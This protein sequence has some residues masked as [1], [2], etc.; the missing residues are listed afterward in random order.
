MLEGLCADEC[1]MVGVV[2]LCSPALVVT[3]RSVEYRPLGRSGLKVSAVSLGSWL[4]M[5][6]AIDQAGSDSLVRR[7]FDLG[8]NLFDTADVYHRG[9]G[10]TALGRAIEGIA[11]ERLVIATKCFFPMSGDVNDRGLSRKHI[12]ESVHGSLGR[13][14]TDYLDLYQCHRP[15]PETPVEETA[16]AM[17]DLIRQGKVLYWGVSYWPAALIAQ[18]VDFCNGADL[19]PPVSNQPPYNLFNREIE[20]DVLSVSEDVGLSQIVYSPLAQG[21]LTG[22]YRKDQDPQAGSR[23]ANEKVNQFIGQYLTDERLQQAARLV[24]LAT[25]H[26]MTPGQMALAWCLRQPNVSSVIVGASRVEQLEENVESVEKKL[27]SEA[28]SH[29]EEIFPA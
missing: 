13:L 18:A 3:F 28:L 17:S 11:R 5:G 7:A 27:S 23:A 16:M 6:N 20:T 10:E 12:F 25:S 22:K 29:L 26:G 9:E 19:H 2:S 15:D 8:V 24:E 1:S 14:G 4:T 21:V